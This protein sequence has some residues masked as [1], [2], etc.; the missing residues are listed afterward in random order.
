MKKG[1][2]EKKIKIL[3]IEEVEKRAKKINDYFLEKKYLSE[4]ISN[5][6]NII[7]KLENDFYDMI[8]LV[9]E[10]YSSEGYKI[11]RD[12]RNSK[13]KYEEIPLLALVSNSK[14]EYLCFC[15]GASEVLC[16]PFTIDDVEDKVNKYINP[17]TKSLNIY[18]NSLTLLVE[19]LKLTEKNAK[20]FLDEY[21]QML[22]EFIP[23]IKDDWKRSDYQSIRKKAHQIKGVSSV[24]RIYSVQKISYEIEK[25]N[26]E[27]ELCERIRELEKILI[28]M[29]KERNMF[30]EI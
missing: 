27:E 18:E 1:T 20:N 28:Q 23:Q 29:K 30:K 25:T 26:Q 2:S 16:K 21:T 3:I 24:L 15:K 10:L 17:Y 7:E 9:I 8:I 22:Q 6:A 5:K 12:I 4:V 14:E 19:K 13:K 11:I